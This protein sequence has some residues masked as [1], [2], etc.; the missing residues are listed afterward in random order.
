VLFRTGAQN[1]STMSSSFGMRIRDIGYSDAQEPFLADTAQVLIA[2]TPQS[3]EIGNAVD[4]GRHTL[5]NHTARA[6]K[7]LCSGM[8][9]MKPLNSCPCRFCWR[10]A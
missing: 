4:G 8:P 2:I 6:T 3:P 9:A 5:P 10:I 1:A 7:E